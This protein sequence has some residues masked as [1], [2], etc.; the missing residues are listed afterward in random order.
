MTIVA[1]QLRVRPF[2]ES[3]RAAAG[4]VMAQA[5]PDKVDAMLDGST[6]AA[7]AILAGLID[8]GNTWVAIVDGRVVGV[9]TAQ[10]PLTPPPSHPPWP[11]LRRH[12]TLLDA[13]RARLHLWLIHTVSVDADCLYLDM[14]AVEP[15]RQ[16]AG[17]GR[18][19]IDHVLDEARGRDKARV[20]LYVI[21]RNPRARALYE[22]LGF[23]A[24]HTEHLR[25]FARVAGFRET[26]YM[27]LRLQPEVVRADGSS[28]VES[29][30]GGSARLE[31]PGRLAGDRRLAA[32]CV[33]RALAALFELLFWRR[34]AEN[35]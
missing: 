25:F 9:A 16:S 30:S 27:E 19:L 13:A 3:D 22:R 32:A 35:A 6:S 26:V 18:Q 28:G 29:A 33:R 2:T 14:V 10:D 12:L 24:L 20:G 11:L 23:V 8:P 7:P 21:A 1:E 4:L 17:V 31:A 34:G 15:D 5:F